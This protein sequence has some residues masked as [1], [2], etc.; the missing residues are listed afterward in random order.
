MKHI[1]L[2][3]FLSILM[4]LPESEQI[5]ICTNAIGEVYRSG[6]I[7]SGKIRKGE[8]I[9][10]GDK[11]STDKNAF[12]SLLNIQDKSI[13]SLYGNSVIKLFRSAE[14]DSIKT[15]INIFGGRVSA[16]LRKTRN[17]KF[18]VNTPS[19][20]AVLKGT[21]FLAG[22][23]TLNDHGP[24]YQGVSDCAFSVLTGKL[25]VQNTKSGK[26]I[27]VEEG[28][29]VISTLN[30]EFLIFET[31]DEFTQYFKEPK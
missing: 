20:V 7:R 8:S 31:T 17:R 19:S 30:G 2:L 4:S 26:T 13:I 14:K 3:F 28:K 21:T 6:K 24:K 27:K 15:E 10:N 16:E 22:H 12:L 23:R 1:L 25:E 9:Y 5:G 29:T 18:V 11:I